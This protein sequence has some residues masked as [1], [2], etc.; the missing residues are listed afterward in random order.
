MSTNDV[1]H[2]TPTRAM[3]LIFEYEG[4]QVRLVSQQPVEMAITG[5]DIARSE[6]SAYYIDTR[7]AKGQTLAR[8]RARGAFS[9]STEVFPERSGDPIT[10]VDAAEARGAFT[11]VV[12]VPDN[13]DHVTVVRMTTGLSEQSVV[14]SRATSPVSGGSEISDLASF[15]L[16][17]VTR[18]P[19]EGGTQ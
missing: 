5:F 7:D 12:P 14:A 17:H 9:T 2:L 19:G 10:R 15:P 11:V 8:V 4:D 6:R 16:S 3:R 18:L 13:A 1:A